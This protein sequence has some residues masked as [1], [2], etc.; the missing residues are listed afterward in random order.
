[1]RLGGEE[2]VE[3]FFVAALARR[4]E[5]GEAVFA[6]RQRGY[7]FGGVAEDV[8]YFFGVAIH[9]GDGFAVFDRL[10][11][12]LH[13]VGALAEGGEQVRDHADAAVGV[14]HRARAQRLRQSLDF[15]VD[16]A[17]D[18]VVDLHER[19]RGDLGFYAADLARN[20]ELSEDGDR[21]FARNDVGRF[22]VDV[23]T[24]RKGDFLGGYR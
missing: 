12:Y 4:V 19:E 17:A 15:A 3:D 23:I 13:A 6:K 24:Q 1:M 5:H 8:G 16:S 22:L 10:R 14:Q 18:F 2:C 9:C 21:L 20:G 7:Y 11:D